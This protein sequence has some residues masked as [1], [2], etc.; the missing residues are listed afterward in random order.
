[1][2]AVRAPGPLSC[3]ARLDCLDHVKA[4]GSS[5]CTF[6]TFVSC[7]WWLVHMLVTRVCVP[8]CVLLLLWGVGLSVA[9]HAP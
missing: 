4:N 2:V 1:M 7:V 6:R 8:T 5:E 9:R 3:T